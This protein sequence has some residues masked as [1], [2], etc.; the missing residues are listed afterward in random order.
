MIPF[1]IK[2]FQFG[3]T[4]VNLCVPDT[5]FIQKDYEERKISNPEAIFPYWAKLWPASIALC[6]FI[7][8]NPA[9]LKNKQVLELAAGLSLPSLLASSFATNVIASDYVQDAVDTINLSIAENNIT[10]MQCRLI[11]W[12]NIDKYIKTDVLLLSDINYS[13]NEFDQLFKVI[14]LF[15]EQQT[16]IIISTPQRI[17]AKKFM[18]RLIQWKIREKEIAIDDD[19]GTVYNSIWVLRNCQ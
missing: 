4:G 9:Y 18:E 8:E 15:I 10:N 2:H 19:N 17:T 12:N 14:N 7:I 5:D 6:E 13:P 11:D 3:L 1:E 16:T